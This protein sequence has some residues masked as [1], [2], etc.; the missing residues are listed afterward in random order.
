MPVILHDV[1]LVKKEYSILYLRCLEPMGLRG[2]KIKKTAA[3]TQGYFT[4]AGK[5]WILGSSI[6][7]AKYRYSSPD[8]VRERT[9]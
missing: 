2:R 4:E 1:Y 5:A 3:G 8:L 7:I 9:S 6:L